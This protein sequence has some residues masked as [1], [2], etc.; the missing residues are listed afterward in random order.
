MFFGEWWLYSRTRDVTLRKLDGLAPNAGSSLPK[1]FI[2]R[3]WSGLLIE[4]RE[5]GVFATRWDAEGRIRSGHAKWHSTNNML[6]VSFPSQQSKWLPRSPGDHPVALY[7]FDQAD[8]LGSVYN[9][10]KEEPNV[11]TVEK[12]FKASVMVTTHSLAI[13]PDPMK[14]AIVE[15]LV[16]AEPP[17]SDFRPVSFTMDELF[18]AGKAASFHIVVEAFPCLVAIPAI[19]PPSG[20]VGEV[21]RLAQWRIGTR[22]I[23]ETLLPVVPDGV[24]VD[25]STGDTLSCTPGKIAP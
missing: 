17:L 21:E 18:P 11:V 15:L 16:T 24:A 9:W 1:G 14:P 25:R 12:G 5:D 22:V 2:H 13:P 6:E 19:R 23:G 3:S 8:L 4:K 10:N 7:S 20:S